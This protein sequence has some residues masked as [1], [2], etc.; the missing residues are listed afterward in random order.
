MAQ[1]AKRVISRGG[2]GGPGGS[3]GQDGGVDEARIVAV[4]RKAC[5]SWVAWGLGLPARAQS[6][7]SQGSWAGG[8]LAE[9]SPRCRSAAAGRALRLSPCHHQQASAPP[10]P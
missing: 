9:P 6:G 2:E 7:L 1:V 4:G 8:S 3:G 5:T 10:R